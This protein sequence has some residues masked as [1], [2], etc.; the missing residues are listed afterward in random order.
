MSIFPH[1][2]RSPALVGKRGALGLNETS[3]PDLRAF[4]SRLRGERDLV[5]VESEV[6]PR[7]EVAEIHRRVI[8]A[9]IRQRYRSLS[10]AERVRWYDQLDQRDT[11]GGHGFQGRCRKKQRIV[12]FIFQRMCFDPYAEI[13]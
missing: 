10:V 6:D 11:R 12:I 5:V 8:A 7:L 4:I 9:G 13:Y 3:F 1:C 2:L